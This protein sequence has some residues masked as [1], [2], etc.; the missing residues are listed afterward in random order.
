MRVC[1][2]TR[3]ELER[4]VQSLQA[5]LDE[6]RA[7]GALV[8]A[9]RPMRQL[10]DQITRAAQ[11]PVDVL[12]CGETGT[13][14]ELIAR[15][16][17]RMSDRTSGPFVAVN[18]AAIAESLAESE[19]FGHV[20]GA[21]TGAGADR[22]GV[23]E[24]AQ[25]GTLFLD[26][27]GDMPLPAQAK[28]LRA[29]QE[30]AVQPVGSSRTVRVDVRVISA[31]HQN[32]EES[33]ASGAFRKDLFYR[34]RGVELQVPPLRSRP[35][36]ILLLA[37]YFLERCPGPTG[38]SPRQ[39][40]PDAV[41]R[42]IGY[43]WPGNVRELAQTISG[44]AAMAEGPMIHAADLNLATLASAAPASVPADLVGLP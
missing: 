6:R 19:L 26:E 27:I 17:H 2:A 32:L 38:Q 25:G 30:R 5:Q 9:S 39:L 29:L 8:G 35:E 42:L 1:A 33:I 12:I 40:A 43:H 37:N 23:F 20:R 31:T 28:I 41:E 34:I 3:I 44:A 16:I 4:H 24:Q 10:Y 18:T 22:S 21:Y 13:G 36:D 7:F 14:K 15:E 11:A